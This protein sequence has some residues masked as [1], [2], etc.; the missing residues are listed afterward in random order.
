MSLQAQ[1]KEVLVND[2]YIP[3]IENQVRFL[4][5]YG[6]GGCFTG[7]TLVQSDSGLIPINQI[8]EGQEVLSLGISGLELK[9]VD[10]LFSYSGDVLGKNIITFT[11]ENG[12][13]ISS[14]DNH[15][16][17]QKGKWISASDIAR[18]ILEGNSEL[19]WDLLCEQFRE[20]FNNKLEG[21]ESNSYNETGTR[22]VRI[23][24]N[25]DL[26]RWQV[27]NDKDSQDNCTS[28]HTESIKPTRGESHRFQQSEQPCYE[29]SMGDTQAEQRPLPSTWE[30]SNLKRGRYWYKYI[31]RDSSKGNK[32]K[33][34]SQKIHKGN[35]G[36]GI[37]GD[38]NNNQRH[39]FAQ[40]LEASSIVS[41]EI[42]TPPDFVYDL[43]VKDNHNYIVSQDNIIVHNSGKSIFAAWKICH[44]TL[45]EKPH[46]FLV[47][48]KVANTIKESVFAEIKDQLINLGCYHEFEIN[49]TEKSFTHK[50]TGNQILCIGLDEPEKIKSIKGITGMWIEELTEFD[51]NDL[52]Q[53]N[54]RIRGEKKN[55]VQFIACFNPISED[56]WAVK[57]FVTCSKLE[58]NCHVIKSTH[59]NNFFL[60]AEDRQQLLNLKDKNPLFYDIYCLGLPGVVDKSG[61]FLYSFDAN[62]QVK[63][64]LKPNPNLPLWITFDFN[65]DPMTVSIGQRTS[66]TKLSVFKNIQLDNS[67]IYQMTDRI[68]ADYSQF[69]WIVT[70]DA[71]GHNRTGTVRGK[72][73]YW[74]IIQSELSLKSGQMMVRHQNLP[75]IE[76][77]VLCNAVNQTCEIEIDESC[78]QLINDCKFGKVK[79]NGE[80]I[81]DRN[82]QK[83]DFLDG[84]RYLID[85]NFSDYLSKP[86]KYKK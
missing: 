6:G 69:M 11:L 64:G 5:L 56:H 29:S 62:K 24:K 59:E 13:K 48:R 35:V 50:L 39:Y 49:K 23:F 2:I 43:S 45:T 27:Q 66:H 20:T 7:D 55:Y 58:D 80:L 17:L 9:R 79:E 34:Q 37:R 70:G 57:R 16:Y 65:L 4:I 67:D 73:S 21:E 61:K 47:L 41:I 83:L 22:R 52:D 75:L 60:S 72:T 32:V 25:H 10:K 40:E 1:E 28:I 46:K 26:Q 54:L 71:S 76:S 19:Q 42:S 81:K 36:E 44:R 77:R 86:H 18:R 85:A 82:K 68:K 84:F 53:L 15:E 12:N 74:K 78:T 14:T 51:E 3:A 31:N 30:I 38:V 8:K 33:I 63:Q